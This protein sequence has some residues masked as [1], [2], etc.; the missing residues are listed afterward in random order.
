[1]N[2]MY[3]KILKNTQTETIK[4][5]SVFKKVSSPVCLMR[6]TSQ[7]KISKPI[8][9]MMKKPIEFEMVRLW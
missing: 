1:M 5:H 4:V 8:Q 3:C 9:F 6:K 7:I 2:V